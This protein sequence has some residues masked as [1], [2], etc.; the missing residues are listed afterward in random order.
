[1]REEGKEER[2]SIVTDTL[3]MR[4]CDAWSDT[5]KSLASEIFPQVLETSF[6]DKL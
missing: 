4:C 6:L 3:Q 2:T 5:L 1:M